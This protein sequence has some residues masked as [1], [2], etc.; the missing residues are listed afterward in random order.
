M[1]RVKELGILHYRKFVD[2][3][4]TRKAYKFLNFFLQEK[5]LVTWI[6]DG[7]NTIYD[8]IF[9]ENQLLSPLLE[10]LPDLQKITEH[11]KLKLDNKIK[12]R[13]EVIPTTEVKPFSITKPRPRSVPVPEPIPR[14]QKHNPVPQS[15]YKAHS[16]QAVIA[17]KKEENRR[18]AEEILMEA[19]RKQFTCANPEKSGKTME[20][21]KDIISEQDSKL[22]F[23]KHRAR[24]LPSFLEISIKMNT[25]AILREGQ[26]YQ[27]LEE[28]E[29]KKIV[30]LE[31]GTRNSH[32][33]EE[34]QSSMRKKDIEAKLAEVE[35]RRLLGKLSYEDAILARQNFMQENR[36]KVA[37]MK[38]EAEALM[39]EYLEQKLK[40]EQSIR[41]L[42]IETLQGH[43]NAKDSQKRLQESKR[44]IADECR[45]PGIDEKSLEEAE[46]D[47]KRKLELIY[48]IRAVEIAPAPR[49]KMLDLTSTAGARLLTEGTSCPAEGVP[50]RNRREEEDEILEAKQAKDQQLIETLECIS[51]HRLEQTR[52]A[53]LRLE[54]HK[55]QKPEQ[56]LPDSEPLKDLKKQV[57]ERRCAR[58]KVKEQ[59]KMQTSPTSSAHY[60]SLMNQ[61]KALEASR[62]HELERTRE[63]AARLTA[64]D[65]QYSKTLQHLTSLSV[66]PLS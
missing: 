22:D 61:K 65:G 30:T 26:L 56:M 19:S 64:G 49:R 29:L 15:L 45:K 34:W 1:F 39:Q 60:V 48:Q 33:F 43:R 54:E 10:L 44:R 2:C 13:K 41:N 20:V 5:N 18:K 40:E 36:A 3:F 8:A 4:D 6:K 11:L 27:K 46:A 17:K 28:E 25:A 42:K 35:R 50:E 57:E 31:A 58:L 55:K 63:R 9:V 21:L 51:K 59:S 38:K 62:W 52:S 32:E 24:P 47:M 53:A 37:Q 12:P 14:L 16:D 7:W 66:M 23:E